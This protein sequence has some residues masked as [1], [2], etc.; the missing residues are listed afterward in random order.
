MPEDN[1]R[2]IMRNQEGQK[3]DRSRIVPRDEWGHKVQILQN[4][5]HD[6]RTINDLLTKELSMGYIDDDLYIRIL[7]ERMGMTILPLFQTSWKQLDA[8][9]NFDPSNP[10]QELGTWLFSRVLADIKLTRSRQGMERM[11]QGNVLGR[12]LAGAMARI[13][14]YKM[15]KEQEGGDTVEGMPYG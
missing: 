5:V 15:P 2:S 10:V 12:L 11:L 1:L 8:N 13:G 4:D 3:F 9:G 6:M 14:G 7:N